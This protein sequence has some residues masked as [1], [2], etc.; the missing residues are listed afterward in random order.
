L[1]FLIIDYKLLERKVE[2]YIIKKTAVKCPKLHNHN[3][4]H[5][6]EHWTYQRML[7]EEVN[8][9]EEGEKINSNDD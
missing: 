4:V 2:E 6:H 3:S 5:H 1:P 9:K 8:I 7:R